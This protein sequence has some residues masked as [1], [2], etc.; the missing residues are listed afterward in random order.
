MPE[1][2]G[3]RRR[4]QNRS[5]RSDPGPAYTPPTPAA[6]PTQP[7]GFRPLKGPRWNPPLWVNLTV[8]PLMIVAGI[9]FGLL[10]PGSKGGGQI[11][12]LVAYL[13]V[14]IWYLYK[15]GVQIRNRMP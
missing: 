13:G 4:T 10:Q 5:R 7:S 2:K 14:G 12:L 8:G 1:Q 15:A 9:Y 3:K 11:F 6:R